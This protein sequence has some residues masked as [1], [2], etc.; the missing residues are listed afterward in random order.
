MKITEIEMNKVKFID[1]EKHKI[2]I[3]ILYYKTIYVSSFDSDYVNKGNNL[4]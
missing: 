3:F 4:T 1:Y 2:Q